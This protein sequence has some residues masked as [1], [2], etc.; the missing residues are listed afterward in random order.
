MRK[1]GH[2][3]GYIYSAED[4]HRIFKMSDNL[5]QSKDPN[6][7]LVHYRGYDEVGKVE[8]VYDPQYEEVVNG[9]V[10]HKDF[11]H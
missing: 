8:F 11:C 4:L 6:T 7:G 2:K 5:G 10:Q 1:T 9:R 3:P